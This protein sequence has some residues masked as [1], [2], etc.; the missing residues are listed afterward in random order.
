MSHLAVNGGTPVGRLEW[1][2]WPPSST[3]LESDVVETLRSG[4]WTISGPYRGQPSRESLFGDAFA[5]Y[6]GARFGVPTCNGTHALVTA[7]EA[8]DVGP[9]DEVIVPGLTWVA[10][11]TAVI[12]LN[13]TPILVDID[14]TLC[15][16]PRAVEAAITSRTK[17]IIA[18]HLYCS[19][20]DWDQ[21]LEVS[22]RHELPLI[23]DAAQAHG[24]LWKG[25]TAGSIG[26]VSAF[27]FQQS[28]LMTS[29][30]GGIALTDDENLHQRMKRIRCDGR[31][32]LDTPVMNQLEIDEKR[33][34]P[35]MGTN[36]CLSDIASSIL[37]NHLPALDAEID[38]RVANIDR[39]A[40]QLRS[41]PGVSPVE[42]LPG[43]TRRPTW[44][45][46]V[47]IDREAFAGASMDTIVEAVEAE[48]ALPVERADSPL[49]RSHLYRPHTKRRFVWP[50]RSA[51]EIDPSRFDLP[52]ALVEYERLLL[53]AHPAL[54]ALPE[55]MDVVAEAMA[56][57]QQAAA[58]LPATV[59]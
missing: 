57:V 11:A 17:A 47:R 1:P 8:L 7:L 56:K 30:E 26:T 25:R 14:E 9:G 41:I 33:Q 35:L 10:D 18:V 24:A 5:R 42:T 55:Q 6:C 39:L 36:Y 32:Y 29:G 16:D 44:Q 51:E 37:L 54:L 13:A 38:H 40:N 43:V 4:R 22:A 59:E 19:M 12:N 23:E 49:N 31:D 53:I 3:D 15:L 34:T 58:E 21:L 2:I 48:T 45:Y 20:P 46:A 52:H 50:G 28:K 27:S